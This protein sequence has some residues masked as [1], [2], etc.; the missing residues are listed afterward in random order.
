MYYL[1]IIIVFFTLINIIS[2][3]H[4]KTIYD[5]KHQCISMRSQNELLKKQ[6]QGFSKSSID[7]T[8]KF[9]KCS[10]AFAFTSEETPLFICPLLDSHILRTLPYKTKVSIIRCC[11]ISNETWYEI[12]IDNF[13]NI[14]SIG[15]IIDGK[16]SFSV[17]K[18]F[19]SS[20]A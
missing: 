17:N 6:I 1:I 4:K 10:S 13:N 5:L 3:N 7:L 14:N 2:S 19:K 15:W 9:Y 8:L 20:T 11:E 18:F 12:S 16:L